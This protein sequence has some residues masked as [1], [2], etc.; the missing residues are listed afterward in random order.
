[1]TL[2]RQSIS[3]ETAPAGTARNGLRLAG[4]L[5]LA[6]VMV[7]AAPA[8]EPATAAEHAAEKAADKAGEEAA[9]PEAA[10]A[11]DLEGVREA[12]GR[13]EAEKAVIRLRVMAA[14]GNAEAQLLL[15]DLFMEGRGVYQNYSMAGNWYRK[16]AQAGNAESQFKLAG[17]YQKGLGVPLYLGRGRELLISAARQGYAQAIKSLKKLGIEPPPTP[18]T[19]AARRPGSSP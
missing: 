7:L 17:L 3:A 19:P 12:I 15:G 8:P 4:A 2:Q 16:A 9:K 18:G 5:V 6:A 14:K 13:G 10:K 1:M 11:L